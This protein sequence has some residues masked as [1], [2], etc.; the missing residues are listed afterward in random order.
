MILS[1][2]LLY[3]EACGKF[4]VI[5]ISQECSLHRKRSC[6]KSFFCILAARKLEREKKSRKQGVVG[7]A[8]KAHHTGMLATQAIRNVGNG[9]QVKK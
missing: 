5:S 8:D 3:W 1:V 9:G 7:R 4:T 2:L 6:T